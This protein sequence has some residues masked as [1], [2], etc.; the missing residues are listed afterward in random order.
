MTL[1][2]SPEDA[3][4]AFVT[5]FP[6]RP[7]G[8]DAAAV[9][10]AWRAALARAPAETIVAGAMAYA[11]SVAGREPRY[12]MSPRRFLSESRWRDKPSP[13][14]NVAPLL[15]IALDAPGWREWSAFYRSTKGKTP[16]LDRRGGWRFPARFPPHVAAE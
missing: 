5:A 1:R 12:V 16:P 7:E 10:V 11:E 6:R 3:F 15:W 4:E 13:S 8:M 14:R 9:R 2:E